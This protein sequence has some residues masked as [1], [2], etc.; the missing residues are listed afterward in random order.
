M[1][2]L[3]AR[4]ALTAAFV[5][6]SVGVAGVA[7][8]AQTEPGTPGTSNCKGQTVAFL[9]QAGQ[10]LDAPGLGNLARLADLSV[11]EVHE[12]VEAYCATP[13]P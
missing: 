3:I 7:T 1:K 13:A 5:V 11:K 9:A 10:D 8:A 12:V 6:G 4:V 2:H